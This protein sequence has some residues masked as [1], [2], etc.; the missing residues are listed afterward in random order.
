MTTRLAAIAV[1]VVVMLSLPTAGY[2][3]AT[4]A[5]TALNTVHIGDVYQA[6]IDDAANTQKW[7]RYQVRT[8]RSYCVEAGAY[9]SG[10]QDADENYDSVV[11]VFRSDGTTLI[12]S[13]DDT[14]QEPDSNLGSRACF[15]SPVA[16]NILV[17]VTDLGA[18][19]H[20]FNLRLVET[21]L[22]ASWFFIGGDYNAFTLLRNTTTETVSYTMTWRNAAGTIVGTTSG[23]VAANA[24]LGINART[25]VN[26]AV[27]INGTMEIVHTG[28]PEALVGQVTSLSASTGLGFDST[29]FK[30]QVW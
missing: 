14:A 30:R 3:Q 9:I 1:A 23:T 12:I 29:L 6:F 8:G 2:G 5:G 20:T 17:R 27:T 10:A 11:A 15:I 24:G 28:S 22:W 18:G 16:G 19:T 13:N 21:T 25:F 4:T 26:A 7:F